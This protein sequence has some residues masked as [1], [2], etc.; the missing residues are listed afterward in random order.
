[1]RAELKK[2]SRKALSTVMAVLTVATSA[3]IAVPSVNAATKDSVSIYHDGKEAE[4]L[5][6][7]QKEKATLNAVADR[8]ENCKYQ[9]QIL[10][11]EK[12]D[13]WANI[14]DATSQS[15]DVS[16]SMTAALLDDS[17][18]VYIRYKV[19]DGQSDVTSDALRVTT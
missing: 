4:N 12:S 19:T 8:N 10:A 16:Y 14:Y 17:G 2:F 3:V 9:W 15:L 5:V 18:S 11:D 7:S 6:I 13:T 1:M